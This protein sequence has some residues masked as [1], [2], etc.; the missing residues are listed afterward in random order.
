MNLILKRLQELADAD[1]F[2]LSEAVETEMQRREEVLG[3]I[4]DSARLRAIERQQSYRRR[5]GAAAPPVRAVGLG[6][7]PPRRRAA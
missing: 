5:N 2:F 4:S 1:L 6:K 3:E 7:L